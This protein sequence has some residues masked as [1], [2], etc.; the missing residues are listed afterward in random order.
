MPKPH[1]ILSYT[2]AECSHLHECLA[3]A[4]AK[5]QVFDPR[6]RGSVYCEDF[7]HA[8]SCAPC[9]KCGAHAEIIEDVAYKQVWSQTYVPGRAWKQYQTGS[10]GFYCRCSQC[11]YESPSYREV[12][13]AIR[14]WN[15]G[16]VLIR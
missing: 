5:N 15:N 12:E 1:P 6:Y 11:E 13:S 3:D 8:L 7:D 16:Q 9:P 4:D 14:A 10:N 2:C